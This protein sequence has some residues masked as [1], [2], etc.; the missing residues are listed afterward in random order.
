MRLERDRLTWLTYLQLG[1]YGYFLYGFGPSLSVLRD[2]QGTSRAV[3]G[4]HGTALAV[5]SLLAALMV[6]RLVGRFGRTSLVWAG[7]ATLCGGSCSTP[8]APPWLPPSA[9]H[10]SRPSAARSWS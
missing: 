9:A 5:G 4:L 1:T 3:A 2:E 8:A 6:A 7:M 10:S